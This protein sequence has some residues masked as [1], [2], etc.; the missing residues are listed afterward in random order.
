M[1]EKIAAKADKANIITKARVTDLCLS[2][3][4]WT[5]FSCDNGVAVLKD[6][7]LGKLPSGR[8][9]G[10]LTNNSLPA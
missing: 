7:G 2:E 3:G 1:V 5:R 6:F 8:F 4:A 10:D 9:G